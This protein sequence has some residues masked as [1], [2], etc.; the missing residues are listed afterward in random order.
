M[1]GDGGRGTGGDHIL[2]GARTCLSEI[3]SLSASGA[4]PLGYARA[5]GSVMEATAAGMITGDFHSHKQ[6][7]KYP[8]FSTVKCGIRDKNL[9]SLVIS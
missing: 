9:S 8:V 2:P 3:Q 5:R 6:Q 7:Q 1:T 4:G